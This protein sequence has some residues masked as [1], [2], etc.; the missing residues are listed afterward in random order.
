MTPD[1]L[2]RLSDETLIALSFDAD[3]WPRAMFSSTP[4]PDKWMGLLERADGTRRFVPAGE[5]PR[6][7]RGDRMLLVR[8]RPIVVPVDAAEVRAA[9]GNIVSGTCELLLRWQARDDDL[10]SL[11]RT[12]LH[13]GR[14]TLDGLAQAVAD[15]GAA[16][17]LHDF[18][19][20]QSA[21]QLVEHDHTDAFAAVVRQALQRFLFS[22]GAELERVATLRFVSR[23]YAEQQALQRETAAQVERIKAREMVQNAA[24]AATTRRLDGL[25]S[26][27]EKLNHAAAGDDT[28]QW[29]DLL[30]ALS[31]GD[32]GRLLENLWRITPDRH[33]ATA[34]VVVAGYECLWFSPANPENPSRQIELPPD[35]GG[36]RS[37]T[38]CP[39]RN[40]LLV[41]AAR[42]VWAIDGASGEVSG[43]FEVPGDGAP[44]TGF[45]SVATTEDRLY[46]THSQL[47]CWNWQLDDADSAQCLL[48]PEGGLPK[49]IRAATATESGRVVFSADRAVML[50]SP[51]EDSVTSLGEADDTIHALAAL[52][53]DVYVGSGS[54]AIMRVALTTPGDWL[55]IHRAR[56]VV[57][58]LQARRWNDLVEL[59]VPAGIEGI[60][61]VFCGE[62]I[63]AR[64]MSATIPI[65]RAWACDDLVMGLTSNRDRL[66]VLNAN[67]AGIAPREVPIARQTGHSVQDA[68]IVLS[69]EEAERQSDEGG[70]A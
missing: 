18:I 43:R 13:A 59:V 40:W 7:Q 3:L 2:S 34:I 54:G 38:H 6:A 64:L 5:E 60:T 15:A 65:R 55:V 62:G 46:A 67:L 31:P 4:V 22:A 47:G 29:H 26:I 14:L 21:E 32:R 19:K 30:P 10:A 1:I 33:V 45:N 50:Y 69:D 24:L 53:H 37:I 44:R 52:E 42:G 49:T 25:S 57:E 68:C 8:N 70:A 61:G 11:K 35:L 48:V 23:S 27:F 56:D 51:A 39:S 17:T 41:G 16:R 36:L 12:L 9:C 66:I 63:V 20:S 58:S 28:M